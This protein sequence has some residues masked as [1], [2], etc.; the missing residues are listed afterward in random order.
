ML[1]FCKSLVFLES[2]AYHNLSQKALALGKSGGVWTSKRLPEACYAQ[3]R[4]D[5]ILACFVLVVS[6]RRRVVRRL[7]PAPAHAG[8]SVALLVGTTLDLSTVP[9]QN[10]SWWWS[11]QRCH[12]GVV[13]KLTRGLLSA[14]GGRMLGA[15][16]HGLPA[17]GA[18]GCGR[19]RGA[20]RPFAFLSML[21][22]RNTLRLTCIREPLGVV[23]IV[24]PFIHCGVI[25][26]H[27]PRVPPATSMSKKQKHASLV[28]P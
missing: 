25:Q 9:P 2:I 12:Q 13:E 17:G 23:G 1:S 21:P 3:V 4:L 14:V 19:G 22:R 11:R 7:L 15:P 6:I 10:L 24:L 20:K 27:R 8:V 28:L 26:G 5:A 18:R 16:L